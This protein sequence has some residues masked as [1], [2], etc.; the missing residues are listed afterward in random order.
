MKSGT[1]I[2]IKNFSFGEERD[3]DKVSDIEFKEIF[4]ADIMEEDSKSEDIIF[5]GE[6]F[7]VGENL[8]EEQVEFLEILLGL[9]FLIPLA[10]YRNSRID[11]IIGDE[12]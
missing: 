1:Y 5:K 9:G 11:E 6:T 10:E 7:E 3:Y 4:D 2:I 8:D 12:I